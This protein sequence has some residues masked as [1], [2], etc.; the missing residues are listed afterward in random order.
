[1]YNTAATHARFAIAVHLQT[2]WELCSALKKTFK[3]Q[4]HLF[5]NQ[6]FISYVNDTL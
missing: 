6:I 3:R 1:M 4:V 5:F 2:V